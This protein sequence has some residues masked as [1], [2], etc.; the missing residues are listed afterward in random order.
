MN[1]YDDNED[2]DIEEL[3]ED[4]KRAADS[5]APVFFDSDDYQDIIGLFLESG[6]MEYAKKAIQRAIGEFPEEPYFHL[7]HAKYYALMMNYNDAQRELNFLE[8]NYT[9]IPEFYI[10]KV[11]ISHAFNKKINGIEL[12]NKALDLNE[13]IP[14]AHLLLAHE[15]LSEDNIEKAVEHSVRAIQLDELAAEDL[16]IVTIDFQ[17]FFTPNSSPLVEFYMRMTEE[18]PM[19]GSLWSGLGL[20]YM[21]RHD[22]DRA[23][24]AFQFQLSLD[25][26]DSIAYVNLAEAQLAAEDYQ[27]ALHNFLIAQEKSELLQFNVQ[28]GRCYYYMQDYDNAM[29]YFLQTKQNDPLYSFVISDIV[30][31]FKAQG[32]FDDARAYL[33]EQLRKDPQ[34]VEAVEE[35]IDLLNPQKQ[36]EEIKDLCFAALNLEN[37]P[38]YSFLNYFVF[39]CCHTD[40]ADLG[41][42]I[43]S[44]YE[45]D[46][47]LCSN[48]QYFLAALYLKKG[49]V[50]KGCEYLEIA[51]Q[52]DPHL[53]YVDFL[54]MD[55]DFQNIPEVS[56]LLALYGDEDDGSSSNL[57]EFYN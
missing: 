19:C 51:L 9:P 16:K 39:Y 20:V 21:N 7:Q 15:Y 57:P 25:E 24:E 42:E 53:R 3:A 31:V 54:E 28:L 46:P 8:T 29:R 4:F 56:N 38:K 11:L 26:D 18:L 47:D 17:G 23:I 32:K 48:V 30:R 14:E 1:P 13:N 27:N 12:L 5:G 41:I 43:C 50:Q 2:N 37:Y 6:E 34:N 35:L 45:Y 52:A 40:G 33:R 36:I 44:E 49:Q 22:F 10:E 55:S